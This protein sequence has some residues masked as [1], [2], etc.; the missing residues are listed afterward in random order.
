[1]TSRRCVSQQVLTITTCPY[2]PTP[3]STSTGSPSLMAKSKVAIPANKPPNPWVAESF[4]EATQT[5]TIRAHGR[6]Y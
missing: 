2:T 5:I 3:D 4:P 6:T 1:M